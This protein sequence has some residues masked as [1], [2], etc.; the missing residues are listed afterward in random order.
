MSDPAQGLDGLRKGLFNHGIYSDVE[1]AEQLPHSNASTEQCS[2][3]KA[4]IKEQEP[5]IKQNN[6]L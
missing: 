4:L 3:C 6:L 1:R 5:S 2:H